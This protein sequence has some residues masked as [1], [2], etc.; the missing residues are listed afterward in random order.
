MVSIFIGS[1]ELNGESGVGIRKQVGEFQVGNKSEGVGQRQSAARA[2]DP[3][4]VGA[5][6]EL[7]G[8]RQPPAEDAS[9]DCETEA[10]NSDPPAGEIE[11]QL[12]HRAAQRRFLVEIAGHV[13]EAASGRRQLGAGDAA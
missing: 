12:E 7:L 9:A 5:G 8:E 11:G 13:A 2:L 6:E 10:R 1:A 4:F 3:Q